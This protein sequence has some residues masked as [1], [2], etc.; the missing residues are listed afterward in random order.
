MGAKRSRYVVEL[1]RPDGVTSAE[2]RAY[3]EDAVASMK[4]SYHPEDPIFELDGDTVK[5]K[6][7]RR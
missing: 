1:F 2:M 5:V 4:G 7:F 6:S 3:I